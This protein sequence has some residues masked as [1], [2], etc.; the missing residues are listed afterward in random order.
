MK[1]EL[2]SAQ[3]ARY[4]QCAQIA[5]LGMSVAQNSAIKNKKRENYIFYFF[6][7]IILGEDPFR[8]R[9]EL[10]LDASRANSALLV[11]SAV[12]SC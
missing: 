7:Y 12:I 2:I 8:F 10:G 11:R 5:Q 3:P 9:F 1:L 6:F 4:S